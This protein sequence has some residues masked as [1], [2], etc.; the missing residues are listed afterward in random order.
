MQCPVKASYGDEAR[1][2]ERVESVRK[3]VE[4]SFG[5]LKGRFRILKLPILLHNAEAIDNVF[6]TCC[7]LQNIIMDADDVRRVWEDD[8][9]IDYAA[10]DGA[11][12]TPEELETSKVNARMRRYGVTADFAST[13]TPEIGRGDDDDDA[14]EAGHVELRARLV[15]HYKFMRAAGRLQ[16]PT[17]VRL[18]PFA[19]A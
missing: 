18:G 19:V 13:G 3:D 16:W 1:W 8:M 17:E 7:V 4:R 10:A 6:F 5:I 9:H 2:S 11:H 12:E 14:M 15:A